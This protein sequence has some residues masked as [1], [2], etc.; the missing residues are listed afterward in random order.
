MMTGMMAEHNDNGVPRPPKHLKKDGRALWTKVLT[1]YGLEDFHQ[2][3]LAV[4]CEALDRKVQAR[5]LLDAEGLT[6]VD[7]NLIARPH[8]AVAIERDSAIRLLR[9]LR[10]LSLDAESVDEYVRPARIQGGKRYA[11]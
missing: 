7:K 2:A 6:T 1:A 3:I 11:G 5:E 4:A 10:E 8:P 9:A